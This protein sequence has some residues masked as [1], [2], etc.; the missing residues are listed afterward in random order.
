MAPHDKQSIQR[1]RDAHLCALL[2]E[3]VVSISHL[4]KLCRM[5]RVNEH[6]YSPLAMAKD[7]ETPIPAEVAPLTDCW[8]EPEVDRVG[9]G[10]LDCDQARKIGMGQC[11]CEGEAVAG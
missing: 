3:T 1:T 9:I 6:F 10:S 11:L 8:Y 7:A 5:L 4:L 2:S